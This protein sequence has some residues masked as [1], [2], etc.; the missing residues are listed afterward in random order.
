[1]ILALAQS[2]TAARLDCATSQ[3]IWTR[4]S[5]VLGKAFKVCQEIVLVWKSD[6]NDDDCKRGLEMK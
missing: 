2:A 4:S 6:A 5:D 1:M 3:V